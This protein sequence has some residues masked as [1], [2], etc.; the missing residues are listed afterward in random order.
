M[1]GEE[2][3]DYLRRRVGIVGSSAVILWAGLRESFARV[4]NPLGH[5]LE[6]L[7]DKALLMDCLVEIRDNVFIKYQEL[8]GH[9]IHF[10]N[11]LRP[12]ARYVYFQY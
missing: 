6:R 5:E 11:A 3:S 4:D 8:D 2:G 10:Q 7:I 12:R 9:K 1:T